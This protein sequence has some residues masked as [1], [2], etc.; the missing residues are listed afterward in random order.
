[1][2]KEIIVGVFAVATLWASPGAADVR[3]TM[4]N[5]HVSLSARDATIPQ[6]LAEWARVGQTKIINGERV[7]G[8][9]ITLELTDMPE[10]QALEVIL[11]SASGYLAAPRATIIANA[12]R[13]DRI[14]VMPTSTGARPSAAPPAA[15]PVFQQPQFVPSPDEDDQEDAAS[16]PNGSPNMPPQGPP[17]G[18][19]FTAFPQQ[20]QEVAPQNPALRNSAPIQPNSTALTPFGAPRA[21]AG[22]SVP[23]MLVPVPP[24][25]AG[26][27]GAPQTTPQGTPQ[28]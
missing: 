23:G 5:G 10:E 22:V 24:P 4:N 12:S 15:A 8:T 3:L 20:S 2:R 17:R 19:V 9:P 13:Y 28:D 6:I 1:M 14:L 26:Q 7:P 18:P 25:A 27:P 21:P 16:Q 11:R